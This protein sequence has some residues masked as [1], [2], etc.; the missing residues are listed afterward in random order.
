MALLL[1]TRDVD[2]EAR[3]D[4]VHNAF[5]QADVPREVDLTTQEAVDSTRIE[6]WMFGSRKVFSPESP[7][8]SVIRDSPSR[9][10]PLIALCIQSYGTGQSTEEVRQQLLKPG[11]LLMVD[12][13]ARNEF[14]VRG[15]TIAIEIPVE[16]LGVTVEVARKA[17]TR[18]PASPLFPLVSHYLLALRAD[19]DLVSTRKVGIQGS[20][21]FQH[22][23][24]ARLWH[25]AEGSATTHSE[26]AS[27][28]AD[29]S[30]LTEL[31]SPLVLCETRTVHA[32]NTGRWQFWEMAVKPSLGPY[33]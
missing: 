24:S 28:S 26:P 33:Q 30:G 18:L 10:D 9:L 32:R 15:A 25:R 17:S 19:A 4:A 5:V 8:M 27:G 16:E 14:L 23:V 21:S 13:T 20:Q 2:P 7:G 1:D 3:R 11:D 6:G 31:M 12:P 29:T 22:P